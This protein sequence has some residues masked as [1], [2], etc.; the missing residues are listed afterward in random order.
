MIRSSGS[1]HDIFRKFDAMQLSFRG[2]LFLFNSFEWAQFPFHFLI[3]TQSLDMVSL[4]LAS[5]VRQCI[6]GLGRFFVGR[7]AGGGRGG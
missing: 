1:L 5:R 4:A 7:G 6:Q 3:R 2:R